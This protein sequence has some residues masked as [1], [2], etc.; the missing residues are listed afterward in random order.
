MRELLQERDARHLRLDALV[1]DYA[2]GLLSKAQ[3]SRAKTTAEAS[4][5]QVEQ[6]LRNAQ[7]KLSVQVPVGQSLREA[8]ASQPDSWRRVDGAS[9]R[10]WLSGLDT[11][12]HVLQ[13]GTVICVVTWVLHLAVV[14]EVPPSKLFAGFERD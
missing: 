7:S 4:L 10:S 12:A 13:V 14:P 3:F 1:D 6:Q 5:A 8:W 9:C 2:T 11:L